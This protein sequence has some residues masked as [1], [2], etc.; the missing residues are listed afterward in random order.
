MKKK[1][2]ALK[3]PTTGSEK[4]LKERLREGFEKKFVGLGREE[5]D[6]GNEMPTRQDNAMTSSKMI[7]LS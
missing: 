3:L 7:F 4:Q 2:S 1:L 6:S 5:E